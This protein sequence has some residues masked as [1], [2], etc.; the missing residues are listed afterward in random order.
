MIASIGECS[1]ISFIHFISLNTSYKE[2]TSKINVL[3]V[4]HR[5]E[6]P[7]ALTTAHTDTNIKHVD[8]FFYQSVLNYH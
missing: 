2:T 1:F 5:T 6:R 4:F 3:K 8:N 7:V